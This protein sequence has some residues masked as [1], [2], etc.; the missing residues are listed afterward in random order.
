MGLHMVMKP[1]FIC[2]AYMQDVFFLVNISSS[3]SIVTQLHHLCEWSCLK[4]E[5]QHERKLKDP[6]VFVGVSNVFPSSNIS[7]LEGGC[8]FHLD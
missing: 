5:R 8:T 1:H 7:L 6:C 2:K 4:I 3:I